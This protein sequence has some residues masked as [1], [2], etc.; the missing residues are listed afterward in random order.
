MAY[1][2]TTLIHLHTALPSSHAQQSRFWIFYCPSSSSTSTIPKTSNRAHLYPSHIRF[3]LD[4]ARAPAEPAPTLLEHPQ[5]LPLVRSSVTFPL[6]EPIRSTGSNYSPGESKRNNNP[7]RIVDSRTWTFDSCVFYIYFA[8]YRKRLF[9]PFLPIPPAFYTRHLVYLYNTPGSCPSTSRQAPVQARVN[10]GHRSIRVSLL[11]LS[12]H[13]EHLRHILFKDGANH[14]ANMASSPAP[15]YGE[16]TFESFLKD[17]GPLYPASSPI[18]GSTHAT[19]TFD[20]TIPSPSWHF[21]KTPTATRNR[22]HTQSDTMYVGSPYG[23]LRTA[24]SSTVMS[25]GSPLSYK[26]PSEQDDDNVQVVDHAEPP[27]WGDTQLGQ[28]LPSQGM[29]SFDGPFGE[30]FTNLDSPQKTRSN[31]YIP[32]TP[33]RKLSVAPQTPTHLVHHPMSAPPTIQS[34]VRRAQRSVTGLGTPSIHR[35]GGRVRQVTY[36]AGSFPGSPSRR[37]T[38]SS[39]S[40]TTSAPLTRNVSSGS[41]LDAPGYQSRVVSGASGMTASTSYDL[42]SPTLS[43][44]PMDMG[45]HASHS[46][47]GL[48]SSHQPSP[49]LSHAPSPNCQTPLETNVV[50][51]TSPEHDQ[52]G[53]ELGQSQYHSQPMHHHQQGDMSLMG[54]VSHIMNTGSMASIASF[55]GNNGYR[56]Q[57]L[58]TII[59]T[60]MLSQDGLITQDSIMPTYQQYRPGMMPSQPDM[61]MPAHFNPVPYPAVPNVQYQAAASASSLPQQAQPVDI[62]AWSQ[63][64]FEQVNAS[65]AG[66]QPAYGYSMPAAYR[67]VSS[68][69]AMPPHTAMESNHPPFGPPR[70]LSRSV[71]DGYATM[72]MAMSHMQSIPTSLASGGLFGPGPS[73]DPMMDIAPPPH[74]YSHVPSSVPT[75]PDTPRKR[76]SH[77]RIGNPLRPGPKPKPKT[78]KKTKTSGSSQTASSPVPSN[79]DPHLPAVP[80]AS[81]AVDAVRKPLSPAA[82]QLDFGPDLI[83]SAIQRTAAGGHLI[84]PP[85]PPPQPQLTIQPPRNAENTAGGL[86]RGFLETLYESYSTLEGSMTGLPIKRFKCL[87]EGCERTFP[88]KSA[89]HSHI[90]THLEDKPFSCEVEDWYVARFIP[91]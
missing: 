84:P 73:R 91:A 18:Q 15:N 43:A 48:I 22:Q 4:G 71:S 78:P 83:T 29:M 12:L 32:T 34:T 67:A 10:I 24:I 17:E 37:R 35:S 28:G 54:G 80:L 45:M 41:F 79:I 89:I 3:I 74:T 21:G 68:S 2:E 70:M 85:I 42:K 9:D 56:Q 20:P 63:Q 13:H 82:K 58:D 38:E 14:A 44:Y 65:M 59:E 46:M 60:P 69:Y 87:I 26:R 16:P 50:Y 53:F 72:P 76:K 33:S 88:R 55:P 90:Q 11:P 27:R 49:Q 64:T 61:S 52:G 62:S 81:H 23:H 51:F 39:T 6:G 8:V 36:D 1:L 40:L 47:P 86:S 75:S 66:P 30:E 31:S 77:P 5:T 19:F 57:T 7:S 25:S